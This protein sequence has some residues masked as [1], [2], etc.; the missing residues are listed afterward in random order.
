LIVLV[1]VCFRG[2]S[3]WGIPNDQESNL[4][5]FC[6]RSEQMEAGLRY[7]SPVRNDGNRVAGADFHHPA[8]LRLLGRL[9]TLCGAD[10]GH[11]W[12]PLRDDVSG[13]NQRRWHGLQNHPS[14]TLKTLYNFCSLSGCADGN[15]LSG[16]LVQVGNGNSTGRRSKAGPTTVVARCSKLP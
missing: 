7:F 1:C 16:G 13:R 14:G 8:H 15:A 5:I 9:V 11:R 10:P 3:P 4:P 6:R 2:F 12:E